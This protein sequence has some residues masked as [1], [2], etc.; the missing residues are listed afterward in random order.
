MKAKESVTGAYLSGRRSIKP[1]R[2]DIPRTWQM[3]EIKNAQ[4]NNLSN[5]D[6]KI[7]LG[8]FTSITGVSGSGKSSLIS[9]ILSPALQRHLPQLGETSGK[10]STIEGLEHVDK[11]IIIDQSPIGRTPRSNPATYTKVF[12][13]IRKLFA[14]TTLAKERGYSPGTFSFNVKGGRCEACSGAGS[15]KL[16]MNFLPDVWIECDICNGKPA[17]VWK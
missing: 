7:P 3:V 6:A 1:P 16:E 17:N 5:I 8:C 12:D 9:G 10:H 2:S 14:N 15:I 4:H 13:E 11:A